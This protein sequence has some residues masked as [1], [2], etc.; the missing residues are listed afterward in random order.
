MWNER[1]CARVASHVEVLH[2]TRDRVRHAVRQVNA[3]VAERDP[4]ERRRP[5]ELFARLDVGGI[6]D[7]AL[8]IETAEP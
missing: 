5:S 1:R 3:G 7:G 2:E 8:E 4:C 6:V